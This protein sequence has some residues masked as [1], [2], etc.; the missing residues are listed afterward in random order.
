MDLRIEK[1]RRGIINSFIEIRA[2]KRLEKITVKELCD[3]AQINKSTFY[4]HY[5][6]IYD[7]SD[8]LETEVVASIIEQMEHPECAVENPALFSKEFLEGY[9][10]KRTLI[11]ILFS[12]S[13]SSILIHKIVQSIKELVFAQHPEHKDDLVKNVLLSYCVYGGFYALH[14][15]RE[16]EDKE[17]A[18]IIGS[19]SA[20]LRI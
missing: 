11:D 5:H 16:Y 13:R 18:E 15:N 10:A 14:E 9:L 7:L 1:T 20:K 6:D 8:Q 4:A 2:Q 3:K 12:D 19:F 17:L